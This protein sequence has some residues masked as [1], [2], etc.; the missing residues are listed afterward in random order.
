MFV[1]SFHRACKEFEMLCAS[2]TH[3]VN[4]VSS[5]ADLCQV[6]SETENNEDKMY[7]IF[8]SCKLFMQDE[9]SR[10]IRHCIRIKRYFHGNTCKVE[11]MRGSIV[12]YDEHVSE[13]E[14]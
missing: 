11:Y 5:R 7:A 2:I 9:I 13:H 4:A 8:R 14:N 1:L 3:N 12:N 10:F 6:A